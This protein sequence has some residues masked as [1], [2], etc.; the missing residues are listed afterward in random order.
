MKKNVLFTGATGKMGY[1]S[2]M[3]VLSKNIEVDLTLLVRPSSKNEKKM[4]ILK[5]YTNVNI[6]WGDLCKYDDVKKA[7]IDVD[8][9]IH[10][11]ALVSPVA[12]EFPD[13]AWKINYEGSKNIINVIKELKKENSIELVFI[14]TVAETGNRPR[15][16]H[17]GRVGDPLIPSVDDYYALSKIAAERLVIESGIKKWVSLRQTGIIHENILYIR[18]GIEFH[19]PLNNCMEWVS[20]KD[21]ARLISNLC[22]YN[23][24]NEFWKNI[25]NIGGGEEYRMTSLEFMNKIF[26]I[27][28]IDIRDI[29]DPNMFAL[30]NF[31]GHYF[32]DSDELNNILHFRVEDLNTCLNRITHNIPLSL[33]ILKYLPK[34]FM[35]F[36]IRKESECNK[37]T[38]LCWLKNKNKFKH[39]IR[40]FI[41]SER[42][43]NEINDW[44]KIIQESLI[45][46][47]FEL[48]NHGYD[49]RKDDENINIDDVRKAAL[50]RGGTCLSRSMVE[51]DMF[52]K[53][54]WRCSVGHEFYAS[55]FLVL[56]SGHWCDEC[57]KDIWREDSVTMKADFYK[58]LFGM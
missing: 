12:D 22:S 56:K 21:S 47:E 4:R 48:L 57:M 54:K 51:G 26:D 49:E 17:W 9:I 31:H 11:G 10:M 19:Q 27:I 52:S 6:I 55:P 15:P 30:K 33:K 43:C 58:Q 24:T 44:D 23:L 37:K 14:G 1:A 32:L 3:E 41:G 36:Y 25:Y 39:Q 28:Q 2:V 42:S 53:L 5:N 34:N 50:F 40:S 45:S 13:L 46:E 16:Y 35:K 38:P 29:Y 18:D 7:V 20:L 8:M